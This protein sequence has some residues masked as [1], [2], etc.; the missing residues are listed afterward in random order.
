MYDT[1]VKQIELILLQFALL[2]Q[3]RTLGRS[4]AICHFVPWKASPLQWISPPKFINQLLKEVKREEK[5]NIDMCQ[6]VTYTVFNMFSAASD[7][8]CGVV[9]TC[10]VTPSLHFTSLHFTSLH[11][12]SLH[13]TSLYFTLLYFISLPFILL[14]FTSL[15]WSYFAYCS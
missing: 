2:Q 13:F 8:C 5:G 3:H 6:L 4:H 15:Y 12:T 14:Y 1:K 10:A 11:F 9:T 7:E